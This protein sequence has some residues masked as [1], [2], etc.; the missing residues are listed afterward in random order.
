MKENNPFKA[1]I[2]SYFDSRAASDELFARSY[3][4]ENKNLDECCQYILS[5]AKKQGNMV[6]MTDE[7]V[8]NLA[9]HYYDEDDLKVEKVSNTHITTSAPVELTEEEK[10]VAKER[11]LKA[12][13]E[14]EQKK[15]EEA[16][17]RRLEKKREKEA[18]EVQPSLFNF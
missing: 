18:Q 1:A 15:I 17:K 5:E 8:Y 9:V 12:Y 3:A 13:Q 4:K 7:E 11:A 16:H 10:E 14:S 6:A 2:K